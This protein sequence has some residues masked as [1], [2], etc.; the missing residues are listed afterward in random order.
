MTVEE[1]EKKI[2]MWGDLCGLPTDTSSGKGQDAFDALKK[3]L[4]DDD[5]DEMIIDT[6]IGVAC[7]NHL[8]KNGLDG[9]IKFVV[10]VVISLQKMHN[11]ELAAVKEKK[12][13]RKYDDEPFSS[14]SGNIL[15]H[16]RSY[17]GKD[18]FAIG[19]AAELEEQCAGVY[20]ITPD[21]QVYKLNIYWKQLDLPEESSANRAEPVR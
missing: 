14:S 12:R 18:V 17:D 7:Q 8:L 20:G 3:V 10:S 2:K 15:L 1:F 19:D 21:R 11:E 16:Y 9:M 13:W 5:I 6:N 4:S